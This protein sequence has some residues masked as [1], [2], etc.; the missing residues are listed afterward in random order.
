M[1]YILKLLAC[2]KDVAN[3]IMGVFGPAG[4]ALEKFIRSLNW[5]YI[6]QDLPGIFPPLT[7][8]NIPL[9]HPKH[10]YSTERERLELFAEGL[11]DLI[12]GLRDFDHSATDSQDPLFIFHGVCEDQL[13]VRSAFRIFLFLRSMTVSKN[14][15][16]YLT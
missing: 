6:F 3:T 13:R 15:S 12:C 1:Y 14:H 8:E 10:R 7:W 5:M 16:M 11:T 4:I 9:E 2:S